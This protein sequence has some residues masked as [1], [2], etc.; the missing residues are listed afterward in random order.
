MTDGIIFD[1]DGTLWDSTQACAE[2]WVETMHRLG[3][4]DFAATGEQA[5]KLFGL[6]I[7]EIGKAVLPPGLRE[8]E[9]SRILKRCFLEEND[10][11]KTHHGIPFDGVPETLA[12]LSEK[13]PLFI[14]SN[15]QLGYI[16]VFFETT[17]LGKYF[18]DTEN[19]G[20][21][22]LSKAENIKLVMERNHLK[23]PVYVGDTVGD[24]RSARE[25]GMP[26]VY[27]AY[28][29]GDVEDYDFRIES[30]RELAALF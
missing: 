21:T 15:C 2:S 5:K 19:P 26:F 1:L 16:D 25:A 22:G 3:Y 30:F 9:F 7:R 24:R 18:T 11:L 12:A 8:E 17:G 27:A 13:Y 10:Y 4:T 20:R 29:F 14:V 23:C 28:G 6:P